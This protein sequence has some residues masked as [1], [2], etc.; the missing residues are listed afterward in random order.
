MASTEDDAEA[1]IDGK[2]AAAGL[3]DG[4][5]VEVPCT[6]L[7]VTHTPPSTLYLCFWMRLYWSDRDRSF[8]CSELV[9]TL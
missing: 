4:E 5:K 8:I 9:V 3:H 2:D 1:T 7:C 6:G